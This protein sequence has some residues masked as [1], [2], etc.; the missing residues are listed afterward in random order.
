MTKR[1]NSELLMPAEVAETLRINVLTVYNYIRRGDLNAI[2]LGR[3]YRVTREDLAIFLES[4][5][6]GK[7]I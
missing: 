4:K 7:R 2:R 6:L 5:K 1:N 3:S